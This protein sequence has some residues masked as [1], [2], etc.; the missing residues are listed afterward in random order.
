MSWLK[1]ATPDHPPTLLKLDHTR[2]HYSP[3]FQSYRLINQDPQY[4]DFV[5]MQIANTGEPMLVSMNHKMLELASS[6]MVFIFKLIETICNSSRASEGIA[7]WLIF[8]VIRN[9]AKSAAQ[10]GAHTRY[11]ANISLE[12]TP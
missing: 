11:K 9:P 12:N 4:D 7:M 5:A 8:F 3:D 6:I 2:F 10:N 1:D